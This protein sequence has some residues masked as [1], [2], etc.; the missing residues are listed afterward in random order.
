[1]SHA[2]YF[3]K[4]GVVLEYPNAKPMVAVEGRQKSTIYLPAELVMGNELDPRVREMLPQIASFTPEVRNQAVEKVKAFLQPGTQ[5]GTGGSLLPA[6]GVFLGDKRIVAKAQV[7][8]APTLMAAGV[9]IPKHN[10]EHWAPVLGRANFNIDPKKAVQ[11]NV[12]VF[13][14]PHLHACAIQVYERIRDFLNN[15]HAQ[16][17]FGTRPYALV[18]TGDNERHWGAFER[19]FAAKAPDNLFVLDFVKPRAALDSA[20]PV[21]K[22]MLAKSGYLSQFI[23][24]KTYSHDAPRDMKKSDMILGAV[25]RQVL[26]KSGVRCFSLSAI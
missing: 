6:I 5:R 11:L 23:N 10:A 20:Y 22:Q 4:K 17:R 18:E 14:H 7:L 12:V 15:F 1:M 8:P 2:E 19:Y 24:F 16:Y 21:V 13:H 3:K 9:T 25:A 26:Q